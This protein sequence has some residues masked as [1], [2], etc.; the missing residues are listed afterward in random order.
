MNK[1]LHCA[2]SVLCALLFS[3]M[4]LP[5][6]V[7]LARAQHYNP[8]FIIPPVLMVN[9]PM[10]NPALTQCVKD[11]SGISWAT[12]LLTGTLNTV[13]QIVQKDYQ[14]AQAELGSLQS[15]ITT[16]DAQQARLTQD[17]AELKRLQG[18]RYNSSTETKAAYNKI[19]ELQNQIESIT[20]DI[21]TITNEMQGLRGRDL[22]WKQQSLEILQTNL[23]TLNRQITSIRNQSPGAARILGYQQFQQQLSAKLAE[24]PAQLAK[25]RSL[26]GDVEVV[27]AMTAWRVAASKAL[28]TML[29]GGA[30]G[31][32]AG[33]AFY[34][35][36]QIT[37]QSLGIPDDPS[38]T[39]SYDASVVPLASLD[40]TSFLSEDLDTVNT[41]EDMAWLDP[42]LLADGNSDESDV[43]RFDGA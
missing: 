41:T 40:D 14:N 23:K 3:S 29:G 26:L 4:L 25:V 7:P 20:K 31:V 33:S 43:N 2:I 24:L 9:P 5:S 37:N 8:P 6:T 17:L 16:I 38:L 12:A 22:Q 28:A 11:T 18:I 19:L 32:L 36:L 13:L 35:V 21:N 1:S 10:D 42:D 15:R 39:A 34:C 30:I 27:A